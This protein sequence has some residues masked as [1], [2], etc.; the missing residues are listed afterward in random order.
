ML[1]EDVRHERSLLLFLLSITDEAVL[2]Q[3]RF[4]DYEM[5]IIKN[6]F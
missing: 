3:I 1:F 4:T 2:R 5:N 6:M